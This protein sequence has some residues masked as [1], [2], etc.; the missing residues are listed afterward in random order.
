M[1]QHFFTPNQAISFNRVC[2]YPNCKSQN[3][4]HPDKRDI[5]RMSNFVKTHKDCDLYYASGVKAGNISDIIAGLER[6]HQYSK[7]N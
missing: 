3:F 2:S 5:D 6:Y 1:K 7:D 4:A